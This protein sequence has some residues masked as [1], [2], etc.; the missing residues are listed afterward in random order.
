MRPE[1]MIHEDS[2]SLEDILWPFHYRWGSNNLQGK[3][4]RYSIKNLV[5]THIQHYMFQNR[6]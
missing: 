5:D 3:K 4:L 1:K 2:T 6:C